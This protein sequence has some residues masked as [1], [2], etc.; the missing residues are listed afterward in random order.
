MSVNGLKGLSNR[1]AKVTIDCPISTGE[2]VYRRP[3]LLSCWYRRWCVWDRGLIDAY[4]TLITLIDWGAWAM[5]NTARVMFVYGPMLHERRDYERVPMN[6]SNL[7]SYFL[8]WLFC[9]F[10]FIKQTSNLLSVLKSSFSLSLFLSLHQMAVDVLEGLLE[11]D[12]EVVQ[13]S[14]EVMAQLSHV[15]VSILFPALNVSD[16]NL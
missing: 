8:I 10:F 12:D 5:H 9:D 7:K 1:A 2:C 11:E 13:V 14:N 16:R 15:V 4:Q 3:C 6:L